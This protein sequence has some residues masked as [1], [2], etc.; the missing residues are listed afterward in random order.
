MMTKDASSSKIGIHRKFINLF[1]SHVFVT[2]GRSFRSMLHSKAKAD[3]QQNYFG[4]DGPVTLFPHRNPAL[5]AGARAIK[6]RSKHMLR[7]MA[8]L[9][10][11]VIM[12]S[13]ALADDAV[14][15]VPRNGML[16]MQINGS[17]VTVFSSPGMPS[18]LELRKSVAEAIFG[19]PIPQ[20]AK[21]KE[22]SGSKIFSI[23][24][25]VIG[26]TEKKVGPIRVPGF[27]RAS[28]LSLGKQTEKSYVYWYRVSSYEFG[29]GLAGPYALP[30]QNIR[31]TLADP[32]PGEVTQ[33]FRLML[34]HSHFPLASTS[35]EINGKS[36]TFGFAPQFERT[37][38]SAAV[39]ALLAESYE[40]QFTAEKFTVTVSGVARPA[41][42]LKLKRPLLFGSFRISSLLVRSTDYGDTSTI[43]SDS[44]ARDPDESG[45]EGQRVITVNGRK[46]KQNIIKRYLVYVGRDVLNNCS[47]ITYK[48]PN[49]II[50][51][52]CLQ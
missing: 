47:S 49:K 2:F 26:E 25:L 52:S 40:G 22:N 8:P 33:A 46:I 27:I 16:E 11:L 4:D 50:E 17:T 42:E 39:G 15:D 32:R 7:I 44:D 10:F 13:S 3:A 23:K 30:A 34:R 38:V 37:T 24:R 6:R 43:S 18:E 21:E 14:F 41:R 12:P 1:L 35:Q 5:I 29:D 19:D 9:I 48:K 28:I 31:Y 20:V 51:L 45:S 36:V